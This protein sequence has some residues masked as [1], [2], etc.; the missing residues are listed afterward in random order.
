LSYRQVEELMQERGVAVD[1]ATINRWVLTYCPQREEVFPRRKRPIWL[2]WR[3]DETYLQGRGAW[4]YLDRAVDAT[5]QT[6][7]VLRT[8][9]QDERAAKRFLTKAIRRHEVPAQ[10]TIDGSA[11]HAAA[12]RGYNKTPG[13]TLIIRQVK[14]LNTMVEQDHRGMKQVTR[15]MLGFTSFEAAQGT[16][17]GIEFMHMLTQ[18]LR[19]VRTGRRPYANRTVRDVRRLMTTPIDLTTPPL[20]IYDT[21]RYRPKFLLFFREASTVTTAR[22]SGSAR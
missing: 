15:P 22:D 11:A 7:D 20:K 1:H 3:M 19:G 8:E 4:R 12:M 17:I 14:Y 21:T 10:V 9:P 18:G 2:S 5:G 16:L 6:I 13:R